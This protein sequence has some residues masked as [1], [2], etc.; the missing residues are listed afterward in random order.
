[1]NAVAPGV[2]E[3][4]RY[5]DRPGYVAAEYGRTIPA[6]RVGSPPEIASVVAFLLSAG[7]AFLTGQVIHVDGGTSARMSFHRPPA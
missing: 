1:V 4:P 5:H 2:V 6:G 3:V 7:A